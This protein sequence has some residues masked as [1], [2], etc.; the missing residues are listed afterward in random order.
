MQ[1]K[2]NLIRAAAVLVVT[3]GLLLAQGPGFGAGGF[4][5]FGRM[6]GMM[7]TYLDLTDAQKTQAKSIFDA[8][9]QSAQPLADQ[10]K[11]GRDA[12]RDAVK[13]DDAQKIQ[14]LSQA[15]GVLAGKLMAIRAGALA[16]VYK[17]L[18]PEQKEKADKLYTQMQGS[19]TRGMRGMRRG[20]GQPK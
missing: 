2:Q 19:Q 18:T 20:G 16:D 4:G 9:K 1:F 12:M 14:Q 15:Q 3:G 6:H 10:M 17:I 5:G 11:Q 8:A 7:A 13:A